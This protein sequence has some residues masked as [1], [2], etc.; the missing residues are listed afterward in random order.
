MRPGLTPK[1]AKLLTFIDRRIR[2]DRVSPSYAEMAEAM[3]VRSRGAMCAMVGRLEQRGYV[4]RDG[5][6]ARSLVLVEDEGL[7]P[8]IEARVQDYCR[9]HQLS[10][11]EFDRRA[12]LRQLESAA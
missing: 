5:I 7:P 8:A 10:R 12:A 4:R 1:L 9:D 6:N 2:T 3:G 11:V